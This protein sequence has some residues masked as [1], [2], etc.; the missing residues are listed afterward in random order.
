M[1]RVRVRVRVRAHLVDDGAQRGL[2]LLGLGARREQLVPH[3]VVLDLQGDI[4]RCREIQL[5][6]HEVVL[7]LGRARARVGVGVGVRVSVRV[8][9]RRYSTCARGGLHPEIWGD[10]GREMVGSGEIQ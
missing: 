8:R 3:E 2:A 10:M 7:D 4:G 6:P 1:A 5:V 9:V